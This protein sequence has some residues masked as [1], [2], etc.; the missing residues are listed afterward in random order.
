MNKNL[1]LDYKYDTE[2]FYHV[3]SSSKDSG[4]SITAINTIYD[5]KVYYDSINEILEKDEYIIE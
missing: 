1:L 2:K 3:G 4:K 5:C